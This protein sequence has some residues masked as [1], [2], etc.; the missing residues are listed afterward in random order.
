MSVPLKLIQPYLPLNLTFLES[1]C[2]LT[3][4]IFKFLLH[5]TRLLPQLLLLP[6][7]RSRPLLEL[8]LQKQAILVLDRP[9]S[10][11]HLEDD[12]HVRE[13]N[14]VAVL[15]ELVHVHWLLPEVDLTVQTEIEYH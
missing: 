14:G 4:Q 2:Q 6:L 11:D 15:D 12:A 7:L 5:L 9:V 13:T 3:L 10:R 8:I 1:I